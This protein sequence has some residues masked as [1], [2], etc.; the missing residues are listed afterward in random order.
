LRIQ[1]ELLPPVGLRTTAAFGTRARLWGYLT[2]TEP[3]RQ[4]NRASVLPAGC[5]SE[6]RLRNRI[7]YRAQADATGA[8]GPRSGRLAW[9]LHNLD[10]GILQQLARFPLHFRSRSQIT[11]CDRAIADVRPQT[12]GY[13]QPTTYR[14]QRDPARNLSRIERSSAL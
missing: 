7:G 9:R 2:P 13:P 12:A 11:T 3:A 14:R 6:T 8:R 10:A 1:V 5:R 4:G